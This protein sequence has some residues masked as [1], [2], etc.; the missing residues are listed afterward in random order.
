MRALSDVSLEIL[1]GTFG[2]LGPNG[3]DKFTLMRCIA[4]LQAPT[5]GAIP[6]NEIDAIKEPEK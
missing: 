2:L 6:F 3:A 4:T 1:A 5:D